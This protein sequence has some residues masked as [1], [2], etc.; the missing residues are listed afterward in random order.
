MK[1]S[2]NL[3]CI[4]GT[5][6]LGMWQETQSLVLTGHGFPMRLADAARGW[7]ARHWSS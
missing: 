1:W 6:Y 3:K 2:V 4:P 5:S 7:Q